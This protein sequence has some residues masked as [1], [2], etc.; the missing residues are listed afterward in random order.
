MASG[1][2]RGDLAWILEN[3]FTE[4]VVKRWTRLPREVVESPSLEV[5]EKCVDVDFRTWFSR[6]G[7][8]GLMVGL[9]DLRGLFQP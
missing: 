5:F 2:V 7:G 1:C 6:H 4:R 8:V 3:F 9:D